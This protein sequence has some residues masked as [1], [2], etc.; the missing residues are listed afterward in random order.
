MTVGQLLALVAEIVGVPSRHEVDE[1]LWRPTDA[2]QVIDCSS[3]RQ[4]GWEDQ[5]AL[6]QTLRDMVD[7][8]RDR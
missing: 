3:V 4:L 8:A 6:E 2:S 5:V 1:K 7:V